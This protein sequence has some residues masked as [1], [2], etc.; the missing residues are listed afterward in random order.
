MEQ[1]HKTHRL[2]AIDLVEINPQ[3]GSK[4]DVKITV[5]SAIHIIEAV[6]GYM[7]RGS[8]VPKHVTD[9]PLQTYR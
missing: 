7:R 2:G 5:E 8:M 4:Q 1:V 6:L 9:M 3:I